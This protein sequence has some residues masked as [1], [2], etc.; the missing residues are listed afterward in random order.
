MES[1]FTKK[2]ASLRDK[3]P[4][5]PKA[6]LDEAKRAAG[7]EVPDASSAAPPFPS[8]APLLG[9]YAEFAAETTALA[10][11]GA[12]SALLPEPRGAICNLTE[13]LGGAPVAGCVDCAT[14]ATILRG[15]LQKLDRAI[16]SSSPESLPTL[17]SRKLAL[18][19][20]QAEL[21]TAGLP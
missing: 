16:A 15:E 11:R 9:V 3:L 20:L 13:V 14:H 5:P 12:S 21:R 1:K 18:E 10:L 17:R 6:L 2:R 4:Q 7:Y 19:A 8:A